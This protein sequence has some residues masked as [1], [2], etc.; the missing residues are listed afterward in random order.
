MAYDNSRRAAAAQHRQ[1]LKDL[2][3]LRSQAHEG[4]MEQVLKLLAKAEE[5]L[6]LAGRYLDR[7]HRTLHEPARVRNQR[8]KRNE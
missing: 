7:A 1:Y 8:R 2:E 3:A 6:A 5:A 4:D